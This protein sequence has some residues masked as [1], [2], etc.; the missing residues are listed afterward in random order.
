M[1]GH[2]LECGR[3]VTG[4]GYAEPAFG[5]ET[6]DPAGLSLPLAEVDADG[7]A[8]IT[9]LPGTGGLVSTA[10]C[11][12]QLI[13]EI[14]DPARYLTPDV[15]VDVRDVTFTQVGPDR[16]RVEGARGTPPPP[17]LKVLLGVDEGW[18]AE[19][20]VSFAGPAA[21][22]KA[23]QSA[24]LF[25]ERL[26]AVGCKPEELRTDLIGV[27]SV[28]GAAT[29]AHPDPYEVRLRIAGR[30]LDED[31]VALFLEECN[32][33]WNVPAIGAAGVRASARPL[34]AMV[35]AS[36]PREHVAPRVDVTRQRRLDLGGGDR[37]A[38]R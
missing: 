35:P 34:L 3:W 11:S 7:G 36:L 15:S 13:H 1:I 37:R 23:E 21:V 33:L 26:A 29:P 20:E 22:T 38:G 18:Y 32:D 31:A 10:T 17:T 19:G 4:G 9:K 14:N 5:R 8:V 27:N 25:C 12:L 2:L 24:R 16:V 6:P 30:L 28:L